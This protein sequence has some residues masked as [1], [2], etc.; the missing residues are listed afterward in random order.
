MVNKADFQ[1]PVQQLVNGQCPSVINVCHFDHS[2]L[3]VVSNLNLNKAIFD[4]VRCGRCYVG[5]YTLIPGWA[6]V[7][8]AVNTV[9][10]L[11]TILEPPLNI[12]QNKM[13][14]LSLS[15][16]LKGVELYDQTK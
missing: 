2:K 4:A 8:L 10:L 7:T 13:T 14:I 3:T 5:N 6:D 11:S 16:F 15:H 9:V 1:G 12:Q